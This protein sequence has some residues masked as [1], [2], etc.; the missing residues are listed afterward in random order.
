MFWNYSSGGIPEEVE[1]EE[2]NS[3]VDGLPEPVR[4]GIVV[5]TKELGMEDLPDVRYKN[6]HSFKTH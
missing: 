2:V 1:E 5:M 4:S 3:V 6:F